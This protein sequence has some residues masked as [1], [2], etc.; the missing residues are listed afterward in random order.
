MHFSLISTVLYEASYLFFGYAM[1]LYVGPFIVII[2]I[3]SALDFFD[4]CG[5]GLVTVNRWGSA[6]SIIRKMDC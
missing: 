3:I 6:D 1:G 5:L 4:L 2:A